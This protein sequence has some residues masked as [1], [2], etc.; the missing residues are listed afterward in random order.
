MTL[1]V[2][3]SSL[4]LT[5]GAIGTTLTVSGLSFQPK[6]LLF[7]W[8]GR[9]TDGANFGDHRFGTGIAI[10]T[11]N[12]R[13]QGTLS[14]HN[15]ANADSYTVWSDDCVIMTVTNTG[16]L[17]GKADLDA[18]LSDGFRLIIDDAFSAN[19]RV[20]WMAW[21]GDDLT[22]VDLV[23]I[24][25]PI[26]TGDQDI[27]TAFGLNTGLD[28]KAVIFIGGGYGTV[29]AINA[30]STWMLGAAA[31]NT[32]VNAVCA[33]SSL[34]AA[35]T[36]DTYSYA[37]NGE[38]IANCSTAN[39][40]TSRASL[41]AWLSNG[42]RLNWAEVDVLRTQEFAALVMKGGRWEVGDALTS[43]GTSNQFEATAYV[44]KMLLLASHCKA[45]STSD[46]TQDGDERSV[47]TMEGTA[48]RRYAGCHDVDGGGT[49]AVGITFDTNGAYINLST[50]PS[51]VEGR[52]DFV[53]FDATP[54][55]TYVMADADPVAA[56]F[57][58][59]SCSDAPAVAGTRPP[60]TFIN[61]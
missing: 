59:L 44:P 9:A 8:S 15:A 49:S 18:I 42:F 56:F 19:L 1:E 20:A 37:I 43:T 17:D 5:T 12:R 39:A 61:T 47:G 31:G 26:L 6:A 46:T 51:T 16:A 57:W 11:T 36:M 14:Q 24:T 55:F 45:Q 40:V 2:A 30:D 29:N 10:S 4:T 22:D 3:S 33:G 60:F 35:G 34:D 32:I 13:V 23:G 50:S 27:T 25:E 48:D 58:Y 38:C 41:T 54:G 52:M 53:S 21:G 28:D 7:F